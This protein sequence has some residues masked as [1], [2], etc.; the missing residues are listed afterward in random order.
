MFRFA[1]RPGARV[2]GLVSIVLALG[3]G[4][5]APAHAAWPLMSGGEVLLGFTASYLRAE[6]QTVHT[7]LDLAADPDASVLSPVD[8]EVSFVG[9]VPASEGSMLA[10]TL[11]TGDGLLVSLMPLAATSLT[12]GSRLTAGD[13]VGALAASG[14]GSS[15]EPHLHIGVRHG[16]SYVD[17]LPILG[18]PPVLTVDDSGSES[19]GAQVVPTQ[20]P[21]AEPAPVASPAASAVSAAAPRVSAPRASSVT[22]ECGTTANITEGGGLA[23]RGSG[24]V[25][26]VESRVSAAAEA[27]RLTNPRIASSARPQPFRNTH[28]GVSSSNPARE[29]R[30]HVPAAGALLGA[31]FLA[32]WPLWR[33]KGHLVPDVRPE[34]NDV[35]VAVSR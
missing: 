4:E 3:V 11:R 25:P 26:V 19:D 33:K 15:A 2:V 20:V 35:A 27:A 9:R 34:I 22:E 14:D 1:V 21:I 8:G 23:A 31:G 10:V 12:A 28:V 17:P 18:C 29:S 7:G 30:S 16:E 13:V 5:V 24:A 6:R 32:L